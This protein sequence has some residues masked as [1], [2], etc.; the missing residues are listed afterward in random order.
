MIVDTAVHYCQ[1]LTKDYI[2]TYEYSTFLPTIGND[3]ELSRWLACHHTRHYH[4]VT[5]SRKQ[6]D[7]FFL[8]S[9]TRPE[10]SNYA[11]LCMEHITQG[12][13]LSF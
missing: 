4:S 11:N 7:A 8:S 6:E 10:I 2:L 1:A 9:M 12:Y 13:I 3:N 5:P